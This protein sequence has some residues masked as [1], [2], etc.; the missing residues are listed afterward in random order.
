MRQRW[1]FKEPNTQRSANMEGTDWAEIWNMEP[2][3]YS[4][5]TKTTACDVRRLDSGEQHGDTGDKLRVPMVVAEGTLWRD[6][7]TQNYIQ[8][9][10]N[11]NE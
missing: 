3:K 11:D 6:F 10:N 9:Q 2:E 8:E 4:N 7:R 5:N 1:I